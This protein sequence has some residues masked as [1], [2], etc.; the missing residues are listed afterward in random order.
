[1]S[2]SSSPRIG[3]TVPMDQLKEVIVIL[4]GRKVIKRILKIRF[5]TMENL[6]I[7]PMMIYPSEI[8][9]IN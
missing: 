4:A 5:R 3:V 1:M 2:V 9:D 7:S 6:L 8:D